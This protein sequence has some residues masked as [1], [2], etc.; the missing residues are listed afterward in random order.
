MGAFL[1]VFLFFSIHT[2]IYMIHCIEYQRFDRFWG[3]YQ[4]PGQGEW[5][6][7]L[8]RNQAPKK[9][10]KIYIYPLIH[11]IYIPHGMYAVGRPCGGLLQ[12][13]IGSSRG[14]TATRHRSG[15]EEA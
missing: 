7:N 13:P 15:T 3:C 5:I 14:C 2:C 6:A 9:C 12:P 10:P 8:C 4:L 11:T 1:P